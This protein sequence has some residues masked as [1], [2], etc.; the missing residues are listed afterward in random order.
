[1]SQLPAHSIAIIG[2]AGRFPGADDVAQFWENLRNGVESISRFSDEELLASGRSEPDLHNPALVRAGGVID[3]IELFDAAFFGVNPREAEILDPQHRVFLECAHTALED[4]GYDYERFEGRIGVFGGS[5]T[6]SYFLYHLFTNEDFKAEMFGPQ[7]LMMASDKDYLCSRTSYKLNL[8]GPSLAIQTAC[9]TSLVAVHIACQSL[10]NQEC[11]L[12][13][14]GGV[15][16]SALQK[17][18]YFYQDGGVLSPNGHCRAF[19]ADARGTVPGN[20]AGIV[21][22]KRLE[23]ALADGDCIRAVIVGTAVNNDGSLKIGYTAPSVE[24]QAEVIAEAQAMAG[25]DPDSIS[26][27][28]AHGT[29]TPLGDPIEMAALTEAFGLRSDERQYCALG[30][31]KTNI[32]HLDTAAGVAGLIKT[33]L[34]LQHRMIPPSLNFENPL[35]SIDFE[36][37]PFYV[38]TRLAEWKADGSPRYAG[39]SSFGIGGTN[40]HLIV[41]EAPAGPASGPSR[42]WQLLVLS[43]KTPSSLETASANLAGHLKSR[44]GLDLADAAYTLQVG[45]RAFEHRRIVVCDSPENAA[46]SLASLDPRRVRTACVPAQDRALMMIFPGQG[47]QYVDMGLDLYRNEPVFKAQMDR[48]FDELTPLLGLDLR[49]LLYPDENQVETASRQLDQTFITQSALFAIEY[50]LAQLWMEWGFKPRAFLGHSIGEYVAACLSG[51][52]SLTDALTLVARRGQLM[53]GLPGGAMLSVAAPESA[54]E[55][56]LNHQLALAAVNSGSRCVVAGPDQAIAEL[57]DRLG[58]L[59]IQRRRVATSHAFHSQMMDPIVKPFADLVRGIKLNPPGI[60]YISNV[61]GAWI[62][63]AEAT[64]PGYWSAHLRQTVR[65]ADGLRTLTKTGEAVL[66]EVGPGRTQTR[67][68]GPFKLRFAHDSPLRH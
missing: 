62:T 34:A 59:A 61:T 46:E 47:S 37:S 40:A 10:L 33:T 7:M 38:N 60:P 63:A 53:Q 20:G 11:D 66:L 15:T 24:G 57:E 39:V 68:R 18:G 65:F 55:P 36:N 16:I 64:D 28:E 67:G 22:L 17:S 25:L 19:D 58:S 44:P 48:C 1:M 32:G 29:G 3:R 52:F 51:V 5:G 8:K 42:P 50:S 43:A 30:S 21:V 35:P 31:V 14:A 13:L 6:N 4:A 2:L 45:R 56:F 41:G 49:R 54:I 23:T 9:S 27:L 12:A 26:Y